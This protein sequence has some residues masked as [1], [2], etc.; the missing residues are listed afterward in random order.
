MNPTQTLRLNDHQWPFLLLFGLSFG[1]DKYYASFLPYD[2]FKGVPFT[3]ILFLFLCPFF[4]K[5]LVVKSKFNFLFLSVILYGV[6]VGVLR[7]FI[8]YHQDFIFLP[9]LRQAVSLSIGL[10]LLILF[11]SIYRNISLYKTAIT[12]VISSI[13][14][15]MVGLYQHL[16]N[17]Q[18]GY[19]PRVVSLFSEPSYY[20][21]YLVLLLAP[22]MLVIMQNFKGIKTSQKVVYFAYISLWLLN[23]YAT[24]SGTAVL[25]ILTLGF[26]FFCFYP[27]KF[28]W[29]IWIVSTFIFLMTFALYIK[30][31][32][33]VAI[34]EYA[35]EI[36]SYPERFFEY[37]TFYDRFFPIYAAI[38]N[39]FSFDGVWGLG[40]GGDY[41]EFRNIYPPSTHA[42]MM[43]Q[44]PTFSYFNSFAGKIV[45]YLGIFGVIGLINLF[46]KAFKNKNPLLK[47]GLLNVL[48][49]S[50]W[51]VSNFSLPY[52][53]FW[54]ALVLNT[55]QT[56]NSKK[57]S[58]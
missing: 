4:F 42:E 45:L 34:I 43:N 18:V 57:F 11:Q 19:Y 24:Q 13:P 7:F 6:I 33:V 3:F 22:S 41:F 26:L 46:Y 16:T 56:D 50:F 37:H 51:G 36:L 35:F 2:F 20:G 52:I 9:I 30:R 49:A 10:A 44:K 47:I 54:L 39:L 15:L 48:I 1:I 58:T 32:Y 53:W 55:E 31:G 21:D 12:I 38:K 25:K 17:Y 29:R 8:L 5:N 40:F 14:F 28:S 23:L 27:I